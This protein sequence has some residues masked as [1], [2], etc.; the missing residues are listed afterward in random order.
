MKRCS[1]CGRDRPRSRLLRQVGARVI[2]FAFFSLLL[3]ISAFASQEHRDLLSSPRFLS[4]ADNGESEVL[5]VINTIYKAVKTL[6][7]PAAAMSVAIGACKIFG[8]GMNG[9]QGERFESDGLKQIIFS[10]LALAAI[11]L[12]PSVVRFAVS[13]FP[14][15]SL[16][17]EPSLPAETVPWGGG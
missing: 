10:L 12:L 8:I 1:L 2:L 11:L 17:W 7:I 4:A 16:G 13:L 15:H 3:T 6:A 14:R 5:A 9:S